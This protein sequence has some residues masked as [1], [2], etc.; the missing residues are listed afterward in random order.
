MP[1][2]A[3]L[4]RQLLLS[5]PL[6]RLTCSRGWERG[7]WRGRRGTGRGP[8]S[9]ASD[10]CRRAA[11]RRWRGL[12]YVG[13]GVRGERGRE[14]GDT[15]HSDFGGGGVVCVRERAWAG[16][17]RVCSDGSPRWLC[18]PRLPYGFLPN[19]KLALS[20]HSSAAACDRPGPRTTCLTMT[21][22]R[23]AGRHHEREKEADKGGQHEA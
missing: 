2:P 4:R 11:G 15:L 1:R 9:R 3:S 20:S 5:L 16:T 6:C 18:L 17:R 23:Q 7:R 12:L 19:R 10:A 21:T 22:D 13:V 14:R 8:P